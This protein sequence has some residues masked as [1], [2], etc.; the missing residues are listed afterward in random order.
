MLPSAWTPGKGT[1][2]PKTFRRGLYFS[3][4]SPMTPLG[5]VSGNPTTASWLMTALLESGLPETRG[6]RVARP[7]RALVST[8]ICMAGCYGRA[9]EA[10]G[11]RVCE[12]IVAR[13]HARDI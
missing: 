3:N 13:V 4:S 1:Q 9:S 7:A 12:K 8:V 6:A 2:P 11:V 5:T 10:Y